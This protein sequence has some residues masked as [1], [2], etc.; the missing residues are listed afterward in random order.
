MLSFCVYYFF[1]FVLRIKNEKSRNVWK[2][3]REKKEIC[4]RQTSYAYAGILH[5]N[6]CGFV[7]RILLFLLPTWQFILENFNLRI[8]R[9]G[10][11]IR[12]SWQ[13][14]L[15]KRRNAWET[16]CQSKDFGFIKTRTNRKFLIFLVIWVFFTWFKGTM[17][18]PR[19]IL[20]LTKVFSLRNFEN[21][22]D[23]KLLQLKKAQTCQE[24][25]AKLDDLHDFV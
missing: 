20:S 3:Q 2:K 21:L 10:R 4:Y 1:F 22:E 12:T 6:K 11:L 8:L 14:F 17:S 13:S 25:D 7:D 9:K 16:K 23:S 18:I 15:H 5:A 19:W 24:K